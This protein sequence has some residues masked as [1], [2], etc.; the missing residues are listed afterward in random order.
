M[1]TDNLKDQIDRILADIDS[2]APSPE[3]VD[4]V[5]A[6]QTVSLVGKKPP[7]Q[8]EPEEQPVVDLEKKRIIPVKWLLPIGII[9]LLLTL[10][11]AIV[12]L[13]LL[14]ES[15]TLFIS[16]DRRTITTSGEITLPAREILTK[17]L[18]LSEQINTT[19]T[20]HQNATKAAGFVTFYNALQSPQLVPA[21]T[22]LLSANNIHVV[23]DQAAYI[24][25]GNLATN[26]QITVSA[27]TV[28]VG[29]TG[30]IPTGAINGQCCRENV[31]VR[32]SQFTGGQDAREYK[33]ASE[34][35]IKTAV[36]DITSLITT[37]ITTEAKKKL[38]LQEAMLSPQCQ[39]KTT[40]NPKP[41]VEA[42]QITVSLASACTVF[43]YNRADLTTQEQALLTKAINDQLG[44]GYQLVGELQ[45]TIDKIAANNKQLHIS[46]TLTGDCLYHFTDQ[47]IKNIQQQAA[48]KN[49][50]QATQL[51]LQLRGVHTV[52]IQIGNGRTTI[53]TNLNTITVSVY[54][55]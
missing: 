5:L 39:N 32:N 25:A 46:L 51:L 40:S 15:A 47:E 20:A 49:R 53:P 23:T 41:G 29:S 42:A 2:N 44:S 13:P 54:E 36:A 45:E 16:P 24:P 55:K 1:S 21:G 12:I 52:G 6:T 35:D 48:G 34:E 27:H 19:G 9:T 14:H 26:G 43:A 33:T 18:S 10:S 22:L 17:S 50:D 4:I 11:F 38:A 31:F 7:Q 28:T 37:Q 8:P 30:N 3:E